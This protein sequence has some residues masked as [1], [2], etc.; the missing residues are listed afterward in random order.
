MN[1]ELQLI[2]WHGF[3]KDYDKHE[4]RKNAKYAS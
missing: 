4:S 3:M 1:I 2:N